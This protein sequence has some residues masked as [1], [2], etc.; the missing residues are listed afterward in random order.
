MQLTDTQWNIIFGV[1][2]V[3]LLIVNI[4]LR[5]LQTDRAPIG[6]AVGILQ[7]LNKDQTLMENFAS[8]SQAVKLR[9][10]SWNR[11]K[12][13][14]DFLPQQIRDDLANAFNMIEEI[15]GKINQAIRSKSNSY[16]AEVNLERV[17]PAANKAKQELSA[18]V[19]EN[20]HNR[21]Y[22][23]KRRGIGDLFRWRH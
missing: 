22:Y 21:A 2:I 10:K 8:T 9:T 16:L 5:K 6:R 12:N 20:L 17:K 23:P 4:Y 1:G 7:D 11:N 15:N 14:I 3:L 19:Q 18:W 13:K